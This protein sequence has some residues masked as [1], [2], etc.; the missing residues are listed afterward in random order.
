M[1]AQKLWQKL[2]PYSRPHLATYAK[3]KGWNE[4]GERFDV[5]VFD[6]G[7]SFAVVLDGRTWSKHQTLHGALIEAQEL[8][9]RLDPNGTPE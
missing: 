3:C 1:N 9:E 8:F 6:D 5:Y 2:E 7:D 4:F